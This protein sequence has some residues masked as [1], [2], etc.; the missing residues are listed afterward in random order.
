MFTFECV[1][2][3]YR[4]S[5]EQDNRIATCWVLENAQFV[6]GRLNEGELLRAKLRR[7]ESALATLIEDWEK[8]PETSQ[9][10]DEI[11]IDEHWEFARNCLS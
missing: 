11:N 1:A 8:V 3:N 10:P 7:A 4:I 5:D 2:D 9:V 6:V